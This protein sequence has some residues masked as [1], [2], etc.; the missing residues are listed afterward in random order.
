[1]GMK[2]YA[3]K[4][5]PDGNTLERASY[6]QVI[7][8]DR[9]LKQLETINPHARYSTGTN[10]TTGFQTG[11]TDSEVFFPQVKSND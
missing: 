5:L 6:L 1:M 11:N 4:I 7:L 8:L 10:S 9:L 3:V 2:P